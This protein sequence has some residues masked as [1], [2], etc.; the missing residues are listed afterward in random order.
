MKRLDK[1]D[2]VIPERWYLFRYR[3]PGII[4][5]RD[6]ALPIIKA[7]IQELL[8]CRVESITTSHIVMDL[9]W[10]NVTIYVLDRLSHHCDLC[11]DYVEDWANIIGNIIYKHATGIGAMYL[12]GAYQ[13]DSPEEAKRI[14]KET[15]P[16]WDRLGRT[17]R[18]VLFV[19]VCGGIIMYGIRRR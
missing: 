11:N 4:W 16:L 7:E 9:N 13:L 15:E 18:G 3:F 2:T 8:P 14:T 6:G 1:K 10:L 12:I 19:L 17:V 5:L